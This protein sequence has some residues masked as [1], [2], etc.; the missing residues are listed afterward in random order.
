MSGQ[1]EAALLLLAHASTEMGDAGWIEGIGDTMC[2]AI[3]TVI[4][5]K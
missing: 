4:P 1:R 3:G 5:D 2:M